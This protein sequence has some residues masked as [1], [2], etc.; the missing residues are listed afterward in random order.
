MGAVLLG[1]VVGPILL[2]AGL[3][4]ASATSVSLL[5]NVEL[6]ATAVIGFV[7]F[8]EH[9]TAPAVLG[10]A[11][12]VLSGVLL[13]WA[14]DGLPGVGA[15]LLVM[16]ACVCWAL[17]NHLTAL[18]DGLTPSRST[19]WKGAVAGI[20]N[21][22]IGLAVAP[23]SASASFIIAAIIVGALC[24]GASIVLYITAAQQLGATRAQSVFASAPF[25]GAALSLLALGE[26]LTGT[27][28]AAGVILLA[29]IV[30]ITSSAHEHPHDHATVEH[31]HSHRHDD[32]HH[33]HE[34]PGLP[35]STRH[36][37]AHQHERVS[38][39]HPHWPDLHHRHS[40]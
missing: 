5:L 11:G 7:M 25:I 22:A 38:H 2:L 10:V 35:P 32:G 24:Y 9:F 20:V 15:G 31:I 17:D 18:I 30:A 34:H 8:R 19:L 1:G 26:P 3:R 36:T 12:V 39:A 40:H 29:S 13:T 37:H 6:A 28:L 14:E 33:D 4:M 16:A 23:L 27:Q 21:S